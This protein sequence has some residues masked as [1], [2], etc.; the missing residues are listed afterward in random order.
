M[1]RTAA[2]TALRLVVLITVA[3]LCVGSSDGLCRVPPTGWNSWNWVGT[4]GC[5]DKCAGDPYRCHS[6]STMRAMVDAM[7]SSGLRDA[8]Y[9]YINLSEGWP[10][11][12][13]REG[14]CGDG[15]FPNG[16]I[17]ADPDRY[18]LGMKA[19]SDYVH[20]NGFKFGIYLDAG[21]K[22]CA[23]FPGS[24]GHEAGDVAQAVAWGA[25]QQLRYVHYY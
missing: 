9:E 14:T 22:T 1:A 17:M 2:R 6:E 4:S 13:F 21:T 3:E 8:G 23:E 15:R 11:Q 25:R 24:E 20:N 16:T 7:V 19:L 10:A 18:P 12:C 5:D